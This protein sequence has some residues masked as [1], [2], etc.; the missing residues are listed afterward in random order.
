MLSSFT[1]RIILALF[2]VVGFHALALGTAGGL[3]FLVFAQV[4][5]WDVF[6]FRLSFLAIIGAAVIL[7]SILPRLDRFEPPGSLLTSGRQPD[8]FAEIERVSA[9]VRQ[10]MPEEVYL[11]L[12][13]NAFVTVRGGFMGIGNK[14]V[15]GI[16]VALLASVT[17]EQF[18]AVIAHEFGHYYGGDTKLGPWVYTGVESTGRCPHRDNHRCG[19]SFAHTEQRPLAQLVVAESITENIARRLSGL[20]LNRGFTRQQVGKRLVV[21]L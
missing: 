17:T 13:V 7:W 6:N 8:L 11:T 20:R 14:R 1:A 16:G 5:L 10:P 3:L 2:L 4:A 12:E 19:V 15:M 18:R 9:D 21:D